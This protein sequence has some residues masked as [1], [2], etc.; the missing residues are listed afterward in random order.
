MTDASAVETAGQS[1]SD[2]FPLSG[3]NI[4]CFAKDWSEDP[5]SNNHLM[6]QLAKH[7]RVLWLNSISMRTPSI[8]VRD[9]SKMARKLREFLKG[10]T[11]PAEN[12]CV[13]TP[14]A[15]PLPH[16]RPAVAINRWILKATIAILRRKLK[17]DHFQLWTFL[18]N[19][20]NYIGQLGESAVVYYCVDE[21]SQFSY[22]DGAAMA[23]TEEELCRRADV[24]FATANSLVEKRRRFNPE[25]HLASHGVDHAHFSSTLDDTVPLASELEGIP[26]PILGFYGLIHDWIDLELIAFIA[27]R[28]PEWSIVMIGGTRVD[29]SRLSGFNNVYF[30]G[31]KPYAELPRFCKGFAVGLI[32]FKVTELTSH[33]NPIKLREYLSAG[34]PVVSTDLPEVQYYS[35]LC[36]VARTYAEFENRIAEYLEKDSPQQRRQRSQAMAVETWERKAAAVGATVRRVMEAK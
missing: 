4:I 8:G 29:T 23:A 7:N 30:L 27:E 17:F 32:P 6:V 5:T 28:H 14:I 13:Y 31:R 10:P 2:T 15:V 16:S 22:L 33:I 3:K 1:R 21:W 35:A 34:L 11:N 36:S 24:V 18:P 9:L 20:V 26:R 19:V 25:T 12:L